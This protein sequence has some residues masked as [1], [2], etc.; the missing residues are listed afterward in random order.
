MVKELIIENLNDDVML[1]YV[2][3][4]RW[5]F[6]FIDIDKVN[7]ILFYLLQFYFFKYES[8]KIFDIGIRIQNVIVFGY[9]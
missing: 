9:E 6:F 3:F 8:N 2:I 7:F 5:K 1:D 4:C